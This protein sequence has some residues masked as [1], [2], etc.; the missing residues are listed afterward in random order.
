MGFIDYLDG[1]ETA[2]YSNHNEKALFKSYGTGL[3]NV[4]NSRITVERKESSGP[5]PQPSSN[6][7][8]ANSSSTAFN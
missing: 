2:R 1:G 5:D 6:Q 4:S 8:R 7:D 3:G